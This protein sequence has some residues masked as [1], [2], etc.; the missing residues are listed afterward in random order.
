MLGSTL[1]AISII[2]LLGV[3]V[4]AGAALDSATGWATLAIGLS[5]V[6]FAA[7]AG[8]RLLKRGKQTAAVSAQAALAQDARAPVVYLR[9]FQDDPIAGEGSLSP[10]MLGGGAIVGG[11]VALLNMAGGVASEEE[12]L[13]EALH[14]LGPVVAVG[15]PGEKLPQL[16]AARMYVQDSEWRQVVRGLMSRAGLVVLRAGKT[17]GLWWEVQTAAEIVSPERIVFLLPYEREQYEQFRSRAATIFRHPLPEYPAGKR[18]GNAGSVQGI[19]YFERDWTPHFRQPE[20]F[21]QTPKAWL[22]VFRVMFQ[23]VFEQLGVD[24][25]LPKRSVWKLLM[26]VVLAPIAALAATIVVMALIGA[27]IRLF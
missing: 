26:L 5:I 17:D 19:I 16:G 24:V 13:A 14:A 18:R 20:G 27:L 1:L 3:L 21:Y 2:G 12:Q 23:P 10:S 9:S 22:L 11:M 25:K 8:T 4:L 6:F 7:F 15:K